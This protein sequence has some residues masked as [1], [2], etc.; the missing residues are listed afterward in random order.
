MRDGGAAGKAVEKVPEKEYKGLVPSS[1]RYCQLH[2]RC[3]ILT[4]TLTLALTLTLIVV[5]VS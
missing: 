4:L 1:L 3:G 2:A 5:E